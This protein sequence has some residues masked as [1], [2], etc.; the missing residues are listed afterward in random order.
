MLNIFNKITRINDSKSL[1]KHISCNCKCK[2][3]GRKCNSNQ[4]WNNNK[5][6][7]ESKNPITHCACNN[8]H[9]WNPGTRACEINCVYMKSLNDM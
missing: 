1:T 4:K 3:D 5:C 7:C 8:N 6:Q 2:F 9:V